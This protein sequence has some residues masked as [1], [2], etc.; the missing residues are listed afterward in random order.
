MAAAGEYSVQDYVYS[1]LEN[2]DAICKPARWERRWVIAWRTKNRN[3]YHRLL[4][5]EHDVK[6]DCYRVIT[7]YLRE[8]YRKLKDVLV[9]EP[10]ESSAGPG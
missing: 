5:V 10:R 8:G 9:W 4:V 6:N 2:F 3:D 1:V 7:G